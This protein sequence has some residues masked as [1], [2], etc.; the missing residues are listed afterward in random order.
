MGNKIGRGDIVHIIM[1]NFVEHIIEINQR[2][3]TGHRQHRLDERFIR[4][5]TFDREMNFGLTLA[6]FELFIVGPGLQR[7]FVQL[8]RLNPAA[9][10]S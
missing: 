8:N 3:C 1:P 5:P 2:F 4:I 6:L 10:I 7:F 9:P